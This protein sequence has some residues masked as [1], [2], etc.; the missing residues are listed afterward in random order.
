[1]TRVKYYPITPPKSFPVDEEQASDAHDRLDE[2]EGRK[3]M[4]SNGS[5]KF[6]PHWYGRDVTAESEPLGLFVYK[7]SNEISAVKGILTT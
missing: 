1:M 4:G 2:P 5:W 7:T 6:K 3:G